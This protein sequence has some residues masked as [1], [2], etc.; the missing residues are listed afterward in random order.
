MSWDSLVVRRKQSLWRRGVFVSLEGGG[1]S[2]RVLTVRLGHDVVE[3]LGWVVG[4]Q[5][6]RIQVGH[7]AGAGMLRLTAAGSRGGGT[8]KLMYAVPGVSLPRLSV[9]VTCLGLERAPAYHGLVKYL[10]PGGTKKLVITLPP[11][12]T[13]Q[14]TAAKKV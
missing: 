8:R 4:Q 6:V 14:R 12:L 9:G 13:G 1:G 7:H 11:E 3:E 2:R 5:N 10:I